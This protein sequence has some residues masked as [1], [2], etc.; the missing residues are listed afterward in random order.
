MWHGT[1]QSAARSITIQGF[2]H[3]LG[4]KNGRVWGDGVYFSEHA[5]FALA[6]SDKILGAYMQ[7]VL[8]KQY[9]MQNLPMPRHLSRGG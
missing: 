3:R 7:G 2:D 5:D 6:Y 4:V 1:T 8:A 9:E